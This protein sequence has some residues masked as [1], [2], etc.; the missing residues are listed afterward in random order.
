MTRLH[1]KT[2]GYHLIEG[3][4]LANPGSVISLDEDTAKEFVRRGLGTM[5]AGPEFLAPPPRE[6]TEGPV[7]HDLGS[8]LANAERATSPV[9]RKAG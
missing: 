2:T 5:H 6:E 9:Q 4:E 7:R 1:V 8:K 3:R